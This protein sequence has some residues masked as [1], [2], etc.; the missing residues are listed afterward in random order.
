MKTSNK[1][2]KSKGVSKMNKKR[3]HR[4]PTKLEKFLGVVVEKT[5]IWHRY[6][7]LSMVWAMV[8][9]T[10]VTYIIDQNGYAFYPIGGLIFLFAS[11]PIVS[12]F[13]QAV[14]GYILKNKENQLGEK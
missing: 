7:I 8:F 12:Y 9:V 10:M 5:A 3:E 13:R 4:K 1:T 11:V 6:D 2:I 14:E